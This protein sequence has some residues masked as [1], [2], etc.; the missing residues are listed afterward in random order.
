MIKYTEIKNETEKMHS[1][2]ISVRVFVIFRSLS[3]NYEIYLLVNVPEK[4]AMGSV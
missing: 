2:I 1:I 4:L 3:H